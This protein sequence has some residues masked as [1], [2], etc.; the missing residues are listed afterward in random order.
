M[1]GITHPDTRKIAAITNNPRITLRCIQSPK[2]WKLGISNPNNITQKK[3]HRP[4]IGKAGEPENP[5]EA[6]PIA[7]KSK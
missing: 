1:P 4:I 7:W 2:N 6:V 5:G 3:M